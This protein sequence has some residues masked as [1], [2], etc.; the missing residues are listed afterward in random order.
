MPS[1]AKRFVLTG[2][3]FACD[4]LLTAEIV[5]RPELDCASVTGVESPRCFDSRKSAHES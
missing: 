4:D 3:V 2:N 5:H 1:D